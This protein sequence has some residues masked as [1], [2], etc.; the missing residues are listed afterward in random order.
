MK[1]LGKR[2]FRR[3]RRRVQLAPLE[4]PLRTQFTPEGGVTVAC[5]SFRGEYCHSFQCGFKLV[6]DTAEDHLGCVMS[7]VRLATDRLYNNKLTWS[8]EEYSERLANIKLAEDT[9]VRKFIVE[10]RIPR[11][12]VAGK[13]MARHRRRKSKPS[14]PPRKAKKIVKEKQK[15]Q[16]EEKIQELLKIQKREKRKVDRKKR[17]AKKQ[18]EEAAAAKDAKETM[19]TDLLKEMFG[20]MDDPPPSQSAQRM[21][22]ESSQSSETLAAQ[23]KDMPSLLMD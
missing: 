6:L 4:T 14:K 18:A 9:L 3:R 22:E 5:P 23:P 13:K 2:G 8:Q 15:N 17:L 1:R 10:G 12:Q 21:E 19:A 16:E 20:Q 7:G 11:Q